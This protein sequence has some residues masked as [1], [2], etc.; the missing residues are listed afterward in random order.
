MPSTPDRPASGAQPDETLTDAEAAYLAARDTVPIDASGGRDLRTRDTVRLPLQRARAQA[1]AGRAP[2]AVAATVAAGW[3]FL[4]SYLPVALVMWLA[5]LVEGAGSLGG[6]V[7]IGLG[8]WLLGH[9]VPLGTSLGPV[10]LAP[11]GLAVLIAWRLARAGVHVTRAIG[12]R[13]DGT[14]RQA[15]SVAGAIGVAWG[16]LGL[17]AAL[18]V[19]A[20]GGPEINALRA[21]GTLFAAGGLASLTGALRTTGAL[22][23]LASRLPRY[24]RD[25]VRTG[26]VGGLLILATGAGS[27]GLAIALNGG[28]ASDMISAYRTGVAGQ[29]GITL[30]SL[31]Y[32][33]NAA[34]WAVGYLLGP[35]FSLG[36]H[37][38][39]QITQVSVGALPTVPLVAGLPSGPLG[40]LGAALPAVPLIAAMLAGWLL[41]RRLRRAGRDPSRPPRVVPWRRLT[42]AA[43]MSGPVAGVVLFVAAFASGGPLGGG[44]LSELGTSAW[45]VG[46]IGAGVVTV[47]ALAGAVASRMFVAGAKSGKSRTGTPP[48]S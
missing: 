22:G 7:I 44:R 15:F 19:G 41:H 6:S 40:G 21:F 18:L 11:L 20:G 39:V 1:K 16:G 23:E 36:T 14:M 17:L 25:A 24:L 37:T 31:A 43:A 34:I 10:G 5:Q 12:A 42:A 3:A 27:T 8:A 32:A 29:A 13:D 48:A 33:P 2:L 30:V 4:V 47:G 26:V 38:T 35:G 28:D 9:G 45:Q 46:L